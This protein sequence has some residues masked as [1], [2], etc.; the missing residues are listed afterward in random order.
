MRWAFDY[1]IVLKFSSN[2][3]PQGNRLAKSTNKNLLKVMQRLLDKNLK[4]WHT[5]LWFSLWPDHTRHKVA[6]G[7]FPYHLVYGLEPIFLIHLKIPMLQFINTYYEEREFLEAHLAKLL[8][9]E[10]K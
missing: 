5:Q 1:G 10:E 2:Y 4:D 8:H 3:Y 7:N 6:L 9:L